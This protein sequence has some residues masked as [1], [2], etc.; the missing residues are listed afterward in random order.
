M[1]HWV[2]R[3]LLFLGLALCVAGIRYCAVESFL[4]PS[5]GMEEAVYRGE[6]ILVN[7]WSYGLRLP[8]MSLSG[9]RR[10]AERPVGKG[11]VIVFNNPANIKQT[12][13]DKRE[14]FISRC[15]GT[16][17]E[18]LLLDTLFRSTA[19]AAPAPEQ[20][21]AYAYPTMREAELDSLLHVLHIG[22][23]DSLPAP[24]SLTHARTFTRCEYHLLEQATA[25]EH[26]WL[27]PLDKDNPAATGYPLTIPAKGQTVRVYPWNRTLLLNTLVLHESRSAEIKNDTLYVDGKPA[28]TCRFNKD[29]Y[30]VEADR[31][32]N[33]SDSRLFGLVP[34]DHLIGKAWMVWF[35]KEEHESM[36]KGYRTGRFFTRIR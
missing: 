1:R 19:S 33:L 14:V 5:S 6:H 20:T 4:I 18:T 3:I 23:R 2:K 8:F 27:V 15:V 11:D 25:G 22:V 36:L 26:R 32:E 21:F 31:A 7:K 29:Y 28:Q 34:A 16:P 13:I 12:L 30:W 24:D 9:Y 10:L 17:G 35:S